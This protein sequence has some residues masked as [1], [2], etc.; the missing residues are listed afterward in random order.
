MRTL[1]HYQKRVVRFDHNREYSQRNQPWYKPR[2]LWVSIPGPT[3]W[4][5]WCRSEE[6]RVE[7][8]ETK[9]YVIL[10][11]DA[12]ILTL[13]T[14]EKIRDFHNQYV[15][16]LYGVLDHINWKAV[17]ETYDGIIIAPYQ[18]SIRMDFDL[19]WYYTWDVASGCIWNANAIKEVIEVFNVYDELDLMKAWSSYNAEVAFANAS[20]VIRYGTADPTG[21][22]GKLPL[23][24]SQFKSE[25]FERWTA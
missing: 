5:E 4:P 22:R 15:S 2:G 6:F 12:N 16:G 18:W 8:L 23:T 17:S 10:N 3:D 9:H 14:V 13:N 20:N 24:F 19:F 1:E 7:H 25:Y 11:E 21:G